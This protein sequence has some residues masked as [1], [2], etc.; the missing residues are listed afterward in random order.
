[1]DDANAED[2]R[3]EVI[4]GIEQP[5]ELHFARHVYDWVTRL[6][7]RPSE[8]LLLAARGHTL[9][10]WT[11]PRDSFPKDNPG[12]HQW[13]DACTSM[14]ARETERILI[15]TDYPRDIIDRVN[16]L[17]LRRNWQND[18][19]GRT[20]ED[21]D[22]LAFL[23]T[24]LARYLDDWDDEKTVNILRGTLRKMTPQAIT[25]ACSLNLDPR[26]ADLLRRAAEF[27]QP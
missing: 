26:C 7:A 2:P 1:M 18:A 19:E 27:A 17:I 22:C 3:R 23:E 13:R 10:R 16:S 4:D 5:R 6:V 25:L 24:K 15:D 20:L 21:A 11:V 14:H 12:Y 8:A 9:R